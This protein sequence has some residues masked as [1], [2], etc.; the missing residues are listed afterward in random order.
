MPKTILSL[1]VIVAGSLLAASLVRATMAKHGTTRARSDVRPSAHQIQLSD[2]RGGEDTIEY[3][4]S[5]A[6]RTPTTVS[7][8][9]KS[10]ECVAIE[11]DEPAALVGDPF[12]VRLR[13]RVPIAGSTRGAVVLRLLDLGAQT[14]Q[15]AENLLL[16]FELVAMETPGFHVRP[17]EVVVED[18]AS[19]PVCRAFTISCSE[20]GMP[21]RLKIVDEMSTTELPH[22]MI[23]PWEQM[24]AGGHSCLV[25]LMLP[26][27]TTAAPM[28]ILFWELTTT[29]GDV[30]AERVSIRSQL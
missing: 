10:C 27:P 23:S 29:D 7:I 9:D 14:A 22:T 1:C 4:V 30:F 18:D 16:T 26:E 8:V 28:R 21:A 24:T 2:R 13:T 6:R 25:E 17:G 19:F 11:V 20:I 12:W 5:R 3:R 15:P